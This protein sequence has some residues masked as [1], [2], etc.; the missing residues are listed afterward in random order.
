[1][2]IKKTN[3]GWEYEG[4]VFVDEASAKRALKADLEGN[5]DFLETQ[6]NKKLEVIYDSMSHRTSFGDFISAYLLEN[7]YTITALAKKCG[8]SKQTFHNWINGTSMP[9]KQ[10]FIQLQEVFKVSSRELQ[11]ALKTN[12]KDYLE[13]KLLE[14]YTLSAEDVMK[15]IHEIKRQHYQVS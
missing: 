1:M 5:D 4:I 11:A 12:L 14:P 3:K 15:L 10:N 2:G 8:A 6:G 7:H 13:K 9:N